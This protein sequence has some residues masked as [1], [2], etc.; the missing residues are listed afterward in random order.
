M[1]P[2]AVRFYLTGLYGSDTSTRPILLT[3]EV[4]VSSS[5]PRLSG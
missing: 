5:L 2:H 4:V 3:G 1:S